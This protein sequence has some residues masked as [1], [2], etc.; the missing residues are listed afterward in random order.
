MCPFVKDTPMFNQLLLDHGA[1]VSGSIALHFFL[2]NETWDPED[3]DLYAPHCISDTFF[4]AISDPFS[5]NF[6]L[7]P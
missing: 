3:M 1:V 2:P 5:L 7:I 4:A 6:K